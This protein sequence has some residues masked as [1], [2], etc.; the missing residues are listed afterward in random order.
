MAETIHA[1]APEVSEAGDG[2]EKSSTPSLASRITRPDAPEFIP[3][4]NM[5]KSQSDGAPEALG[6]SG[7]LE[8]PEYDVELKLRDL[9]GDPNNPLYS[10]K[11]FYDLN[12]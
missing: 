4:S 12:L 2:D 7:G 10:V 1:P 8:E 5:A 6:G 3:S 9:Q 11:S